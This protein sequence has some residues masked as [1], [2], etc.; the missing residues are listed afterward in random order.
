MLN[1][2]T[3]FFALII[4]VLVSS[5]TEVVY[6]NPLD[7][8]GTDPVFAIA[9]SLNDDNNDGIPNAFDP[10]WIEKNKPV[11][12]KPP[13]ITLY[14]GDTVRIEKN[15]PR[16]K[17]DQFK[18]VNND[19][20][21]KAIDPEGSK[22]SILV[23]VD[24][25]FIFAVNEGKEPYEII[26]T[27]TDEAK[28]A[29][30]KI[31]Y[32]IVTEL[33]VDDKEPPIVEIGDD[34]VY[35]EVN[36][37]YVEP[38]VTAYDLG[39]GQAVKPTTVST[40][41][42]T[43]AGTYT[44]TYTA[45]DSKGNK[46]S[47]VRYII[48]TAGPTNDNVPPKII[49]K[50]ADS[51]SFTPGQT[52]DDFKAKWVE[53]GFTATDDVDGDIT[54]KV[55]V[56]PITLLSQAYYFISYY[57]MDNA[58][59]TSE[60]VKRIIKTGIKEDN[61]IPPTII[62][63]YG[64]SVIQQRVST[65]WVDPGFAVIDVEDGTIPNSKVKVDSADLVK[66]LAVVGIYN[67]TYS[68]TNSK[69]VTGT[70]IRR[71]QVV[72][73]GNDRT[74]PVITLKGRNPDTCLAQ[75]PY[76]DPGYTAIDDRSGDV[77]A[78]VTV[79]GTVLI[80]TFG[81]YTLTYSV[82]DSANNNGKATRDVWV[83]PDTLTTDLKVRYN[84]PSSDTLDTIKGTFTVFN[85]DGAGPDLKASNIKSVKFEWIPPGQYSGSQLQFQIEYTSSPYNLT[86]GTDAIK[87]AL[88]KPGALMKLTGTQ[89]AGLDASYYVTTK[90][91][92]MV[93]V[94]V[95]GDFAIIMSKSATALP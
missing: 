74:P 95:D 88:A 65:K 52:I 50:G 84:V 44:I 4:V 66:N 62:L 59:N 6:D 56:S 49:L 14:G 86:F 16:G 1:K 72:N 32:V 15:D 19:K 57:V 38:G 11:D 60:T 42:I 31:R 80:S 17:L 71:V 20:L 89:I 93:W 33:A 35:L 77:T 23:N 73:S 26:Y 46:A 39:D 91:K 90:G 51:V 78:K 24:K 58:G 29:S 41:D 83:V 55:V 82:R 37:P 21:I 10:A 30:T 13:V 25:V 47:A 85:V 87:T 53:P 36:K 61:V 34:T 12:R 92:D 81:K 9:G 22:V 8:E 2:I 76:V 5:C 45:A 40:L 64:D 3:C 48:V 94:Q 28:N 75:T 7:P 54:S 79:T 18:D 27:A 67:V 43:K 68:V 69:G 70:K 63:V